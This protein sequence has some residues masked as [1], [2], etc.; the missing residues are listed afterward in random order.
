[1]IILTTSRVTLRTLTVDD[2]PFIFELVTDP[3]W[4]RFI[5]DRGVSSTADAR[6]YLENGPLT[7]YARLGYGFWLVTRNGDDRPLGICGLIRRDHLEHPDLGFAFVPAA[8]GQ[9]F[10]REAAAA[11]L[12]HARDVLGMTRLLAITDPEN[13]RSIRLLETLGF[14]FQYRFRKSEDEEESNLYALDLRGGPPMTTAWTEL[15]RRQFGAGIDMLKRAITRCPEEV[16]GDRNANPQFWYTAYH[17]IFWLDLYLSGA[18][19]GY[20]PPEPFGLDELDPS[21]LLPGRVYTQAEL[22]TFL[23]HARAHLHAVL[24]GLT[25]ERACARGTFRWGEP[26]FLELLVYNLRHVQHHTGQLNLI[27]RQRTNSAPRW[28]AVARPSET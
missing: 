13:L 19:E 12:E 5:G 10:A 1:M 6:T 21:G 2:A 18:V 16:W 11:T 8:R 9:G 28:V 17:T 23:E 25:E 4:L 22:V 24:D 27:L 3:D 14:R 26:T 7:L 20:R 15:M